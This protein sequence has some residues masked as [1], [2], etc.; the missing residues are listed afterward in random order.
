VATARLAWLRFK[1]GSSSD[2][3]PVMSFP[4]TPGRVLSRVMRKFAVPVSPYKSSADLRHGNSD[5]FLAYRVWPFC[6][7]SSYELV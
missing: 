7:I 3:R 2:A 1:R 4:L 5:W 6:P